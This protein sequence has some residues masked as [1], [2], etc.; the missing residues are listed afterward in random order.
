MLHPSSQRRSAIS[1]PGMDIASINHRIKRIRILQKNWSRREPA[2]VKK[3]ASGRNLQFVLFAVG[4]LLLFHSSLL[5]L[6]KFAYSSNLYFYILL[7]P[8]VSAYF[9]YSRR[10]KAFLSIRP[11][12][13]AGTLVAAFGCALLLA[14]RRWAPLQVQNDILCL[15]TASILLILMGGFIWFYGVRTFRNLAFPICFLLLMIPLPGALHEQIVAMLQKGSAGATYWIIKATGIPVARHGFDFSLSNLEFTIAPE[16]SGIRS[17]LYLF[18]TGLVLSQIYL[19]TPARRAA[20]VLSVLPLAIIKNGFRIVILTVLANY[21][22]RDI[23]TG[24]MHQQGGIP[25][26]ILGVVI[27]SLMAAF[28]AKT[29]KAA[30]LQGSNI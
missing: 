12:H 28:F 27:L 30:G 6:A 22:N 21:V 23:F 4:I 29:E 8:V 26:M 16:C 25:F 7:V 20:L 9:I 19:K 1:N 11:S 18:M 17:F 2:L 24:H 13:L 14:G 3:I 15:M 5:S 10:D